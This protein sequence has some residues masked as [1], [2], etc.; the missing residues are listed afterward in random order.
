MRSKFTSTL[1]VWPLIVDVGEHVLVDAVVV[2]RVVRRLL[3]RPRG[4]AGVRVP[5]EDRHR[6]LVVARPLVGVPRSRVAGAVVE[7]VQLGVVAVP[8]PGGA[9]AA[10][11][12]VALPGLDRS[13]EADLGLGAGAVHPPHL[14]AGVDVVGGHEA[15]HAEL[16]ARDAG[17][18]LVLDHHR[19]VGDGLALA[20][21]A[22]LDLPQLL[23][24][25]GVE[26]H[27]GGVEL[28]EEDLA[29][30]RRSRPG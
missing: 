15:A 8:A 9:A 24:R 17:D 28:V 1:R 29:V 7:E 16:A 11:P 30:C 3:I 12:L 18:H 2:P 23:A 21:V 10:L 20:V 25:L 13:R 22:L 6:V 19:R 14:L 4:L 26:R 27:G 5:R